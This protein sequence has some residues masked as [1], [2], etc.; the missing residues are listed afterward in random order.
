MRSVALFNVKEV[1]RILG[2]TKNK[3]GELIRIGKLKA[4]KQG[5]HT[6]KYYILSSDVQAYLINE[7]QNS[8]RESWDKRYKAVKN[9]I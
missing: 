9:K 5:S 8:N 2:I 6:S 1:A 7:Y 4:F 3:V